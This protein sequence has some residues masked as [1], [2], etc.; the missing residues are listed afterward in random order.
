MGIKIRQAAL[1]GTGPFMDGAIPANSATNGGGVVPAGLP[2]K[3]VVGL[4]D[5]Q[6]QQARLVG[7]LG[8]L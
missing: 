4:I 8:S 7:A 2:A 6:M 3:P 1:Q 5:L